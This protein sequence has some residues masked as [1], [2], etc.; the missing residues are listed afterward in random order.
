MEGEGRTQEASVHACQ[1]RCANTEGC[2]FFSFWPDG[3]C[4]LQGP[5][6]VKAEQFDAI[7]GPKR[8]AGNFVSIVKYIM[9]AQLTSPVHA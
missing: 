2:S 5:N 1:T 7:S 3:G 4:H 8:C 9:S 6:A